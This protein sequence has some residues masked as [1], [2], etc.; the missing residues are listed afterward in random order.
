MVPLKCAETE[1]VTITV[2]KC[3]ARCGSTFNPKSLGAEA[4]AAG[5]L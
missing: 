2:L 5:D 4:E 3:W 1:L